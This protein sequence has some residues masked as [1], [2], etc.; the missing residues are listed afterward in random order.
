MPVKNNN[1]LG[2][3]FMILGMFSLSIND[4]SVK[5]LTEYFPVWEIVFFRA[6]SGLIISFGLIG[7][8]GINKIKT[9]KPILHLVRAFSAVGCV[10]FY[11]FGLK[12]LMISENVAI[13]HSGPILAAIIAVPILGEKLGIKRS[14]AICLGFIGVLIIVK[15]GTDVFKFASLLPLLSA[16]F[17]AMVYIS[18][19]S[20]M[21]T[22]SSVAIIFYY[23]LALFA[24]SLFFFPENFLYPSFYQLIRLLCLGVM[25]S[26]GHFFI[27]Q[28]AKYAD[29]VVISPFE[30]TS[31]IFLAIMGYYFYGEV[32]TNSIYFGGL[33][34]LISGLYIVYK[35]KTLEQQ[36][37]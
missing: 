28:A 24:S 2:I 19:R 3:V 11:F 6:L 21:S 5:G 30:Y 13:V 14:I 8:F 25:G 9:Q 27:S 16:I 26:L 1:L 18:T 37:K 7:Y 20:L 33:L 23:S 4:I 17:M 15:P 32:P 35:E 10:V 34:I 29:I 31:F 22:E 36:L 12:Y